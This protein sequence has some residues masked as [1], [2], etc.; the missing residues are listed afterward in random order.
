MSLPGIACLHYLRT[1]FCADI[2]SLRLR[3]GQPKDGGAFRAHLVRMCKSKLAPPRS[4]PLLPPL[5]LLFSHRCHFHRATWLS[6]PKGAMRSFST[7]GEAPFPYAWASSVPALTQCT[8]SHDAH[9]P[10]F[11]S[12]HPDGKTEDIHS[13][14]EGCAVVKG[15]KWTTTIWI[16]AKPFR[17][18][19]WNGRTFNRV[20]AE[21]GWRP[22]PQRSFIVW[23]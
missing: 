23:S 21:W 8:P 11:Y 18:E 14:H 13:T 3:V 22:S 16:H 6:G 19:E 17:P 20:R 10:P 9:T 7:G 1:C 2:L 5:R 4:H 12:I 15:A